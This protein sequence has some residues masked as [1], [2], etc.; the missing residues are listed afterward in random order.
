MSFSS[1]HPGRTGPRSRTP[2]SLS[3]GAE[4][5]VD[6]HGPDSDGVSG[7]PAAFPGPRPSS[8]LWLSPGSRKDAG[9][10]PLQHGLQAPKP[11]TLA[12]LNSG[13]RLREAKAPWVSQHSLATNLAKEKEGV[14]AGSKD[15]AVLP[16]SLLQAQQ[17]GGLAW[18]AAPIAFEKPAGS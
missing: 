10:R 1:A 2:P 5:L 6:R 4:L 7:K 11:H 18:K 14:G 16:P 12:G 9:S 13:H 8:L 17:A 3:L 15:P